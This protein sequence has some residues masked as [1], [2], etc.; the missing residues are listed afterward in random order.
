MAEREPDPVVRQKLLTF[1][2]VGGGPTGVELCGAISELA[3]Y[4]MKNDF[5]NIDPRATSIL[6]IDSGE[7]VLSSLPEKISV[8]AMK[9]L[10]RSAAVTGSVQPVRGSNVMVEANAAPP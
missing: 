2:V 7:R 4:T 9:S 3:H 5:R 1:V 8:A 10:A 6:L